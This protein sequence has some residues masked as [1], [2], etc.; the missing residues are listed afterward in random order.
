M[1][2][3]VKN[4]FDHAAQEFDAVYDGKGPFGQWLDRNFRRDMYERYRLT[5]ET[6][7]NITGKSVLDVGCG[8]GRYSIE[9]AKRGAVSVVG[10]D[11]APNMLTL[12]SHYA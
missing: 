12:A 3:G 10:I 4:Y 7:G 1:T 5:F 9:F 2:R 8:S 6:C 11:F